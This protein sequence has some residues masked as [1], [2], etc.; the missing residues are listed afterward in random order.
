VLDIAGSMVDGKGAVQ[1]LI[2]IRLRP[3]GL[4]YPQ[5]S[6]ENNDGSVADCLREHWSE[7]MAC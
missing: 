5:A 2:Y 1:V 3:G 6:W 4:Q 7:A